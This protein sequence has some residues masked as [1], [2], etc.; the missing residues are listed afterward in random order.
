MENI[1]EIYTERI[2][3]F[4][5]KRKI[6]NR[7]IIRAAF[8]RLM[9]F[10]LVPLIFVFFKEWDIMV[11]SGLSMIMLVA[12]TISVKRYLFLKGRMEHT[13]NLIQINRDELE[14]LDHHFD[15]FANGER[16][17]DPGHPFAHDLDI[18]GE[19]SLYQMINRTSTHFGSEQ[20]AST[21]KTPIT[22]PDSIIAV[23]GAVKELGKK[24]DLVQD[25]RATGMR[26]NETKDDIEYLFRWLDSKIFF[27]NKKFF[28][29]TRWIIPALT[30]SSL[31]VG[32]INFQF[33]SIFI[34][35]AL[36]QL[37]IV[38]L[39]LRRINKE[40]GLLHKRVNIIRK[41]ARLIEYIEAED[42]KSP[43]LNQLKNELT[44]D[45]TGAHASLVRLTKLVSAFDNR[46]NLLVAL[47]LESILLWDIQ[48][49]VRLEK[50]KLHHK[51]Q[52]SQWFSV[53]G[54][55]E[56]VISLASLHKNNPE[57]V[58]PE[59]SEKHPLNA[60]ALGHP[61]IRAEERVCN[62]FIIAH[63][64]EFCIITGANM[65]G[66]STF[67]R[68]VGLNMILA[69]T[70]GPVCAKR[71]LFVPR[72]L[73]TSMRTTDSLQK[74]ES[75]FY[76]E[77]QR[78]K[79]MLEGMEKGEFSFVLLDEIL[80]GTNSKDKQQGS[81]KVLQKIMHNEGT[82]IIATHDLELAEV[83]TKY[84]EHIVNKCF[85]IEIENA[86]I[87]FDYKLREGVTKKMNA[88]LL[89]KQMNIIDD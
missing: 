33:I 4:E 80:K 76:A 89:L 54:K 73:F 44:I 68:T 47:V 46:L 36:T 11:K 55:F 25:Y 34:L 83:G 70:G 75:Y 56:T 27:L 1:K 17:R 57:Y 26:I 16:Y 12:F 2:S 9:F 42:F 48:C 88:M 53:L 18:F 29:V 87:F 64:N 22:N 67:L 14:A 23:Q 69:M 51:A 32:L 30:C 71:F 59:L 10:S 21:L 72:T 66:K 19:A 31:F 13:A 35:F 43:Y 20:L 78:L 81:K 6:L 63:E 15:S 86:R 41:Y 82:G 8:F 45:H 3:S 50:W 40:H 60:T 28:R 85:E 52:V 37:F 74:N 61:F 84:P 49:M 39:Y 65:A 5:Q 7:K 24:I 58:F 79:R 62:D 38:G 77:L